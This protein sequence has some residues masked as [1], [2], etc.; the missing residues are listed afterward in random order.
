MRHEEIYRLGKLIPSPPPELGGRPRAYPDFM[1]P[2]F[3]AFTTVYRSAR[4]AEAQIG[5]PLVWEF[6]RR[7]VHERFPEDP[8][9]W[10]RDKPMK[11]HNW[12]YTKDTYLTD[13]DL[14]RRQRDLHEEL[15]CEQAVELGLCDPDGPGSLT[16]P[17]ESRTIYA[18]GKVVTP[19]YKAKPGDTKVDIETGETTRRRHDPD[20]DLHVVGGGN[21][22]YGNKFEILS[23]RGK[24]PHERVILS[25]DHVPTQGRRNGY[26]A[27]L[28]RPG[29]QAATGRRGAALRWPSSRQAP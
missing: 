20:A 4:N 15:A 3:D 12:I 22:E 29:G 27:C 26:G 13:P 28:C 23:V 8:S 17:D 18:D 5:H 19:L 1:Q 14:Q 2:A 10:L 16:H 6:I 9:M 25:V 7:L 24:E 21:M 11:R